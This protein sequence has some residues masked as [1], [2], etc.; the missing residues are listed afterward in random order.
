MSNEDKGSKENTW[1]LRILT[2]LMTLMSFIGVFALNILMNKLDS[3]SKFQFEAGVNLAQL[4]TWRTTFDDA[5][6]RMES[7]LDDLRNKIEPSKLYALKP[8]EITVKRKTE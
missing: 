2:G 5:Q 1:L 3:F 6:K 4:N 8:D 7:N